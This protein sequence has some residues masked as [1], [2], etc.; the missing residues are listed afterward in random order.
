M[1][2]ARYTNY[3]GPDY[4]PQG[5]RSDAKGKNSIGVVAF[6][7]NE[8]KGQESVGGKVTKVV[9]EHYM[10]RPS[11][12]EEAVQKITE[13]AH[14][15][16]C[17]DQ[18]PNYQVECNI[19]LLMVQGGLYRWLTFG[20]VRV[21]H[22][23]NGQLMDASEGTAPRL[24]SGKTK[25]MPELIQ[26]TA[27]EK[28]ENSFLVCSS[29]LAKY[30]REQEIENALSA[31]ENAEEWMQALKALYEDRCAD[32]PVYIMTV[33][34]PE[35]RKRLPKKA[36]IAIIVAIVLLIGGFF[37]LGAMRRRQGPQQPPEKPQ[38]PQQQGMPGQ[39]PTEPPRP[40]GG[41]EGQEPGERPTEPPEPTQ[42]PQPEEPAAPEQPGGAT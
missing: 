5:I 1:N 36:V 4:D 7:A 10:R 42:P 35:K 24:G 13:F 27:F 8:P 37:A 33:F 2:T 12:K 22:F 31:A 21:Y 20:D 23:V 39:K 29:S 19:G 38:A 25:D 11:V 30:V 28:G 40:E 15:A 16:I 32:E 34:M 6:G 9:I 3:P 18:T 14:D 41:P 17:A 26:P